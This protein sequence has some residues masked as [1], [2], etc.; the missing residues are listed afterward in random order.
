MGRLSERAVDHRAGQLGD[1]LIFVGT[2]RIE[3]G[4]GFAVCLL[5]G[6]LHLL[7][8]LR[9]QLGGRAGDR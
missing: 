7:R 9:R 4:A 1:E 6:G 3:L 8:V 2:R 5:H